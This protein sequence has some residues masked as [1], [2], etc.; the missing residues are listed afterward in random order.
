MVVES[1]GSDKS[2]TVV[3]LYQDDYHEGFSKRMFYIIFILI[4]TFIQP[5]YS[6]CVH[7]YYI[8]AIYFT[9]MF[10]AIYPLK[11]RITLQWNVA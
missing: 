7:I 10:W 5:P 2:L 4:K 1:T 8:T 6:G 9:E 11:K 3:E